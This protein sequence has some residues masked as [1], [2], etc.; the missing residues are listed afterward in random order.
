MI[1]FQSVGFTN[2]MPFA[3]GRF[4]F[5]SSG[6]HIVVGRNEA[7]EDR[8]ESNGSGKSALFEALAW[9]LYGR[10][11]RGTLVSEVVKIGED[12]AIVQVDFK[13]D[14]SE[15][16]VLRMRDNEA[17]QTTLYFRDSHGV[18]LA[19]TSVNETQKIINQTLGMTFEV[20][21]NTVCFG[22]G[23]PYRFVQATDAEKKKVL[24]DIL[25]LKWIE[26]ARSRAGNVLTQIA[27]LV[28]A[29]ARL[30][31]SANEDWRRASVRKDEAVAAFEKMDSL[32]LREIEKKIET[33]EK[34]KEKL[35]VKKAAL[36]SEADSLFCSFNAL[37]N[38]YPDLAPARDAVTL[39]TAALE[40]AV[41]RRERVKELAAQ[42]I[43]PTCEQEVPKF[44]SV[45]A[46]AQVEEEVAKRT[47]E[48]E[49]AK[50]G[51]KKLSDLDRK[52]LADGDA[53]RKKL[54]A[55]RMGARVAAADM[56]LV[57][58]EIEKLLKE[59]AE[60]QRG[61]TLGAVLSDEIRRCDEDL[62]VLDL[63]MVALAKGNEEMTAAMESLSLWKE[64]FGTRGV[65]SRLMA[66]VIPFLNA[67]VDEYA[68]ILIGPDFRVSFKLAGDPGNERLE[69][70][71]DD[72]H[73][74]VPIEAGET[75]RTVTYGMGSGGE[76]RRVDLAVLLAMFDL[77][78][79]IS[80]VETNVQIFDEVFENLD[81]S[82]MEKAVSLL[83]RKALSRGIYV[84]SHDARLADDFDSVIT[85]RRDELGVSRIA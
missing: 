25:D 35:V 41:E 61:E 50:V 18:E 33:L 15:Y 32:R 39:K 17:A 83:R 29:Q 79:S 69:V 11:L 49:V 47:A 6:L 45:E 37:R 70:D 27:A 63:R 10:T 23:L 13:K 57:G 43:C 46:V 42:G 62:R 1:E 31:A 40:E 82:G 59:S 65:K 30:I 72:P 52:R 48:L 2:F 26:L 20:F 71:M 51:F 75:A 73:P 12:T 16:T 64:Y 36:D 24:D 44:F 34:V 4:N 84:I 74:E 8:A 56:A 54:E 38:G 78:S 58:N 28:A 19:A 14:G 22:Q 85:V 21:K 55:V 76:R 5:L 67:K 77:V 9:G 68:S 80:G 81:R 53:V 66:T 7:R 3:E 60:A